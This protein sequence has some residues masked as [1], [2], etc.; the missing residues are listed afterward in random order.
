MLKALLEDRFKVM[1]HIESRDGAV[2]AMLLERKDGRLGPKIHPS[3][4]ACEG[5]GVTL[6]LTSSPVDRRCGIRGRPGSYRGEGTSMMQ[7]ARALGNFPA[8]GRVVLDRTALVG[9]FDWTL[10]WT[11]SFNPGPSREAAPVANPDSDAGESIFSA[12][13]EQL[14][15]RLEGRR[16]PIDVLVVDHAELPTPN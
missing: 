5:A 12:L 1:T 7:L 9:V 6:P 10:D 2:Y 8:V 11:P 4:S 14:G 16:A 13:R 3:T 15:L